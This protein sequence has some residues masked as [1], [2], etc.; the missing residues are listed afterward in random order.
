MFCVDLFSLTF[1]LHFLSQFSMLC[2]WSWRLREAVVGS[3]CNQ[4]LCI[5]FAPMLAKCPAH[6]II[7]DFI[8][9]RMYGQK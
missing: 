9:L 2:R 8:N 6:L 4:S 7:F 3:E 1:I 5:K